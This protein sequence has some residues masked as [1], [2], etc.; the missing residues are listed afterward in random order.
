M[1]GS[2]YGPL[3]NRKILTRTSVVRQASLS[4][5]AFKDLEVSG[6]RAFKVQGLGFKVWKFRLGF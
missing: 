3:E 5:L 1:M 4:I 2:I 6:F